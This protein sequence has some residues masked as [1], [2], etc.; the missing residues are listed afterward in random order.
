LK[1]QDVLF[2]AHDM[3]VTR[4]DIKQDKDMI[5]YKQ[6]NNYLQLSYHV[7]DVHMITN[8]ITIIF[9]IHISLIII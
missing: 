7:F 5:G 2:G 9:L 3:I 8:I 6:D 4:Y 1:K